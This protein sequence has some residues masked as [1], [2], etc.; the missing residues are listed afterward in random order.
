MLDSGRETSSSLTTGL[1]IPIRLWSDDRIGMINPVVKLEL[2]SWITK[3]QASALHT[4]T[5]VFVDCI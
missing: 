2:V 1:I 3:V 4:F 5:N